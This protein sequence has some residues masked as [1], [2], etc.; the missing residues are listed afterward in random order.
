MGAFKA[1]DNDAPWIMH[2]D[3]PVE[4]SVDTFEAKAATDTN[5][6]LCMYT[7]PNRGPGVRF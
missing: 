3:K 6:F 4:T 2:L 1:A 7:N 5:A